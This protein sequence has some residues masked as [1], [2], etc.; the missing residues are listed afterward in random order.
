MF[1]LFYGFSL[2]FIVFSF[3]RSMLLYFALSYSCGI[4]ISYYLRIIFVF[5]FFSLIVSVF[6]TLP[7]L[8]VLL[9]VSCFIFIFIFL[10]IHFIHLCSLLF[11]HF[12]LPLILLQ[13]FSSL[14]PQGH[15]SPSLV[16]LAKSRA[17]TTPSQRTLILTHTHTHIH[18]Y[19]FDFPLLCVS[20]LVPRTSHIQ[21]F[22]YS[23][24]HFSCIYC[25][26]YCLFFYHLIFV[27][28]CC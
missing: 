24:I 22:I 3:L 7:P 15:K 25:F 16:P 9:P 23:F 17:K 27:L 20:C 12:I 19:T 13:Y 18:T 26:A 4:V 2:F 6:F 14:P 1:V 10:S 8:P 11:P 28:F 5:M 21:S